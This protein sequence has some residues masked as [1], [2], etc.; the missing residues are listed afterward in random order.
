MQI[1]E[2]ESLVLKFETKPNNSYLISQIEIVE[3]ES[4]KI[5]HNPNS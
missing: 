5:T 2:I 1:G 3:I 4:H